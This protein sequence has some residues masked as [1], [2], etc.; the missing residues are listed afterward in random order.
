MLAA[1]SFQDLMRTN[2]QFSQTMS[3]L[4]QSESKGDRKGSAAG[5]EGP[6]DDATT[7]K[8]FARLLRAF[9]D[10]SL[11]V[12]ED[13]KTK[14]RRAD[15]KPKQK[16]KKSAP[17]G[18][19][20]AQEKR[21]EGTVRLSVIKSYIAACGG[22]CVLVTLTSLWLGTQ[23]LSQGGRY[24]ITVWTEGYLGSGY[25]VGF[26]LAIY[27]AWTCTQ[28]I[29]EPFSSLYFATRAIDGAQ[30]LHQ[31]MFEAA[32]VTHA[33]FNETPLGRVINRLTKDTE[34]VDPSVS[35]S[36]SLAVRGF[37]NLVGTMTMIAIIGPYVIIM[38]VPVLYVFYNVQRYFQCT[39]REV[40]RLDGV[41]RSP[42]IAQFNQCLDGTIHTRVQP[43]DRLITDFYTRVDNNVRMYRTG[44]SA[45]RC[46]ALRLEF[47]GS[48]I[49]ATLHSL[50]FL[51][52]ISAAWWLAC[53]SPTHWPSRILNLLVRLSSVAENSLNSVRKN[54]RVR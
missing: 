16:K 22:C 21:A 18:G 46:I 23:C 25:G 31:G 15:P 52:D 44:F 17:S 20:V 47:L 33:F 3:H 6:A 35:R 1:G 24:W 38:F 11:A 45:N 49:S 14:K 43:Q 34:D 2:A 37:L 53:F 4:G 5:A 32:S 28:A 13:G 51:N 29:F 7:K 40:K 9:S 39:A 10:S 54:P 19:L 12:I 26:Y 41:T 8:S 27:V 48:R 30:M 36:I 42:I 50:S